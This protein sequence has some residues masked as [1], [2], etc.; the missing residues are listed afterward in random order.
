[1]LCHDGTN[2]YWDDAE[3]CAPNSWLG[4]KVVL[5]YA[6]TDVGQTAHEFNSTGGIFTREFCN[7]DLLEEISLEERSQSIQGYMDKFFNEYK[8]MKL[9]EGHLVERP[10]Q[11]HRVYSSHKQDLKDKY[12]FRQL[13]FY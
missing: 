10:V 6:A 8:D 3:G 11:H 7:V 4:D 5:H 1:V 9:K 2:S 12:L 13:G